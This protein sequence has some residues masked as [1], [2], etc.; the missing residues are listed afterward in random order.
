[1]NKYCLVI[2]HYKQQELFAQFLPRL[3]ELNLPC[4]I[5]DDGSGKEVCSQ[6]HE[7]VKGVNDF[8]LYQHENNR[9]K[10]AAVIT[11][12]YHASAKG[13]SH[14]IQIDADGQHNV[15]DVEKLIKISVTRPHAIICGKPI[16]DESAP[17]ARV[18]G[19]KLTT[20]CTVLET[21]SFKIRDGHFG[22][23]VYPVKE[24]ERILDRYFIGP[25]MDFDTDVIVKSVWANIDIEFVPSKVV[26]H[27]NSVSHYRY[28][29]DNIIMIRL[30]VRL[31]L[32][33]LFGIHNL[34]SLGSMRF[35]KK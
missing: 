7:M 22:F 4:F 29:R 10:G 17:L 20:L 13:F 31:I 25:G 6:L 26:Y 33:R 34:V 16:F 24:F 23:R 19:R 1:M 27:E 5:V 30:H 11:G 3:V 32:K 21:F 14:I 12:L 9:G 35:L 15:D 8:H 2:P 18:I 28:L